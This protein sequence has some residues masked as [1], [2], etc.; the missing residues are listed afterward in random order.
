MSQTIFV[1]SVAPQAGRTYATGWWARMLA[2]AGQKVITQKFM[3][4]GGVVDATVDASSDIV[5]H[6]RLMGL[7][8]LDDD[9]QRHTA[10]LSIRSTRPPLLE[11][12][13]VDFHE[14]DRSMRR[15]RKQY[16]TVLMEDT[17]GLMAPLTDDVCTI[18]YVQNRSLPIAL[19]VCGTDAALHHAVM[20]LEVLRRRNMRVEAV[21]FN[22]YADTEETPAMRRFLERYVGARFRNVR[23]IDIPEVD[24]NNLQPVKKQQVPRNVPEGER[25]LSI[26]KLQLAELPMVTFPGTITVIEDTAAAK[27][28]LK[29]LNRQKIVGIDTETRPSFRKGRTNSP[30]LVQISTPRRAFLFRINKTGFMPELRKFLETEKVKKVGLS[31]KDD[32]H[33]LQRIEPSFTPGAFID[34][35]GY[36]GRFDIVDASLQKIYGIIFGR[37]ISKNQRLSNWEAPRLSEAQAIYGAIDA[38]AALRI[39]T[40]LESGKFD[41]AKSKYVLCDLPAETIPLP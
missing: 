28:A 39:Y 21:L 22:H 2:A 3:L 38:W 26:S 32:V 33:A 20:T 7:G 9:V 18:D 1:T 23:V 19:V 24:A 34:L 4:T 31:L 17:F 30:S 41:P 12:E 40:H 8:L 15:L 5:T 27:T 11:G 13:V 6:R 36:V 10:P 29:W 16:D 35:Q 37:R 25:K 14:L